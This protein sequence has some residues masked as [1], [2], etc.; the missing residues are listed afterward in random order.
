MEK[1]LTLDQIIGLPLQSIVKSETL[2]AQATVD[3]IKNV[4]FNG[5]ASD[6]PNDYGSL[7]MIH[8][9]YK[10]TDDDGEIITTTFSVPLLSLVPIPL[11]QIQEANID[12]TINI[13]SVDD[14]ADSTELV[15]NAKYASESERATGNYGIKIYIKLTQ[16]ETP[17]GISKMFEIMEN[18]INQ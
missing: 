6:D 18:S 17:A 3:Y 9:N 7:V 16:S 8:F 11:M 2:A 1:S 5:T 13:D 15:L 10:T 12:Y 14:K 4:G